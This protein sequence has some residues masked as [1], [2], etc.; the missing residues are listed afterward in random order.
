MKLCHSLQGLN[1]VFIL[2]LLP[3][4]D[5]QT[6]P[7]IRVQSQDFANYFL[8]FAFDDPLVF[9]DV[10]HAFKWDCP[11]VLH[12]NHPL[13]VV[14]G[15]IVNTLVVQNVS[16]THGEGKVLWVVIDHVLI[17]LDPLLHFIVIC[18]QS[19]IAECQGIIGGPDVLTTIDPFLVVSI[20]EPFI[21]AQ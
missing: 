16:I 3:S 1:F 14:N 9:I 19:L 20:E 13:I 11:P 2:F 12:P 18:F 4:F 10:G 7:V 17:P 6:D 8:D 21:V 15:F 5:E